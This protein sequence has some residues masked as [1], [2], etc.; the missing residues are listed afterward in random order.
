MNM[1]ST[2]ESKIHMVLT[3]NI[4]SF[5]VHRAF[6]SEN[7]LPFGKI[8]SDGHPV[9][10]EPVG[11]ILTARILWAFSAAHKFLKREE[12]LK[13]ARLMNRRLIACFWDQSKG[14][15]W[16]AVNRDE[17][18][19]NPSKYSDCQAY[20]IHGLCAYYNTSGDKEALQHALAL[21]EYVEK[22]GLSDQADSYLDLLDPV[23]NIGQTGTE[24]KSVDSGAWRSL[25]THLH[26]LEA[27]S[28]LY[29]DTKDKKV[30]QRLS[31]LFD[32]LV[33][34]FYAD[35]LF[36]A[37][38]FSD[39]HPVDNTTLYGMNL[40]AAWLL[41]EASERLKEQNYIQKAHRILNACASKTLAVAVD[42][43]GAV[44]LNG[45]G[46]RPKNFTKQWWVQ[47]ESAVAFLIAYEK[48]LK[49]HYFDAFLMSWDFIFRYLVD[50]N[51][52]EWRIGMTKNLEVCDDD[53]RAGFWKCPYHNTRACLQTLKR[54]DLIQTGMQNCNQ[55]ESSE[56]CLEPSLPYDGA[57]H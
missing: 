47:A 57:R 54:I 56:D 46:C 32:I 24:E 26:L 27:Y 14:G 4:L 55:K 2:F 6:D 40:E 3:D 12:D 17:S 31:A 44:Y 30:Q 52:G 49:Q 13:M 22:Y 36:Y 9:L 39:L 10:N 37:H 1:K 48:S 16:Y 15:L 25:N 11:A 53:H 8:D 35:G 28:S 5:W 42:D 50:W 23:Q 20:G 18:V 19:L 45:R 21:F 34:H 29:R 33:D 41:I 43:D 7:Q 51:V 38:L